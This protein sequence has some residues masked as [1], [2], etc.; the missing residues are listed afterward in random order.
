VPAPVDH[1]QRWGQV[2][3]GA[4][5]GRSWIRPG[6]TGRAHVKLGTRTE[7]PAEEAGW[8]CRGKVDGSWGGLKKCVT[9]MGLAYR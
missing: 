6:G 4:P 7:Q 1:K 8:S 5:G 2:G 3:A 9:V